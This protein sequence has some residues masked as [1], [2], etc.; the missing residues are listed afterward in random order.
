MT[1]AD[2]GL[3]EDLPDTGKVSKNEAAILKGHVVN[4]GSNFNQ[5]IRLDS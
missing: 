4:Y 3:V 2:L 5:K 1:G